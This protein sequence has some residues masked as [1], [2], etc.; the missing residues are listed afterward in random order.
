M[1]NSDINLH[2]DKCLAKGSGEEE[3]WAEW[4]NLSRMEWYFGDIDRKEAEKILFRCA[5]DS[6]LVRKSSVKDAFAVSLYNHKKQTV[7]H[8]LI[9]KRTTGWAFQDTYRIYP[10][11]VEVISDSPECKGLVPPPKN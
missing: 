2:I 6:F 5:H 7:V 1:N 3:S 9:E 10:T 4:F 8:S 11:L